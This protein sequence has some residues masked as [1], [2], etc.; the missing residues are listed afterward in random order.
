MYYKLEG[1][2]TE[3]NYGTFRRGELLDFLDDYFNDCTWFRVE[4]LIFSPSNLPAFFITEVDGPD[5]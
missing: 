4:G 1:F 5:D 2:D 3:R